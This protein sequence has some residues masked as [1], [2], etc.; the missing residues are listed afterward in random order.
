MLHAFERIR[1]Q[2]SVWQ[3]AEYFMCGLQGNWCPISC[4]CSQLAWITCGGV[5]YIELQAAGWGVLCLL[6][7]VGRGG[8]EVKGGVQL[9][10]W[11]HPMVDWLMACEF[12]PDTHPA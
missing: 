4:C 10:L 7:M 11:A 3:R 9:D 12:Y 5:L 2:P 1:A 8:G 6:C